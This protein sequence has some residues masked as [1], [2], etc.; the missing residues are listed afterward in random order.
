MLFMQGATAASREIPCSQIGIN[1]PEP[2]S[3][4]SS[5]IFKSGKSREQKITIKKERNEKLEAFIDD[6]TP[7]EKGVMI[8]DNSTRF[9]D[10][11]QKEKAEAVGMSSRNYRRKLKKIADKINKK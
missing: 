8:I 4:P 2:L 5:H 3:V 1:N 10:L 9:P 11:E 6:L 7:Q